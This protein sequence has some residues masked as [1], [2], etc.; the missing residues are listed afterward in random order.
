MLATVGAAPFHASA[1]P[2]EASHLGGKPYK[3]VLIAHD[4]DCSRPMKVV[5]QRVTTVKG[6]EKVGKGAGVSRERPTKHP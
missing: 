5:R 1:E 3:E 6:N 2:Y 4:R